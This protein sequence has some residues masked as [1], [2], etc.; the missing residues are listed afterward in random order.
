VGS[1]EKEG[2][3][4]KKRIDPQTVVLGKY[5]PY[6]EDPAYYDTEKND[7]KGPLLPAHKK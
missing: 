6:M 2:P 3:H 1:V 7:N 4:H 5:L